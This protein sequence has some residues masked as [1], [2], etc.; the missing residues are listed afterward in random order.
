MLANIKTIILAMFCG[1]AFYPRFMNML[2]EANINT[3]DAHH[4]PNTS[5]E[6]RAA[7]AIRSG[8]E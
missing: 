4:K 7:V 1:G 6:I 8:N 5:I 3:N 2:K